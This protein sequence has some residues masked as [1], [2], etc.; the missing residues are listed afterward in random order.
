MK[1][2]EIFRLSI[3]ET[4]YIHGNVYPINYGLNA[5][6]PVGMGKIAT[7]IKKEKKMDSHTMIIDNGDVIQGTP[8]T[9][10]FA[11]Y[12]QHEPNPMIK[13]L[14]HIGYDAAVLGNHEFNYGLT[15]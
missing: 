4:T 15:S 10:H 13:I 6:S 9:Y 11:R 3:L 2:K 5:K 8:L 14:N 7:L 1:N 12:L